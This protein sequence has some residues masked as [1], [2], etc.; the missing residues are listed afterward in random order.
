MRLFNKVGRRIFLVL[1]L[2]VAIFIQ[3]CT[4]DGCETPTGYT[5]DDGVILLDREGIIPCELCEERGFHDMI[6]VL[7]SKYCGACKVVLPILKGLSKELN[8]DILFLDLS[9]GADSL[10]MNGFKVQP[11]YTPTMIVG[12]DV[13]IGGK[14][15][16]EYNQII[17]EFV[18]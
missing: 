13:Y 16:E 8:T 11:Y 17:R 12:C 3:G 9:N 10:Q 14:S 18:G 15:I 5:V 2:F 1:A 4:Q 6:I 7:E